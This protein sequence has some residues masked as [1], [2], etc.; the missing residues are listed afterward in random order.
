MRRTRKA[1]ND[2]GIR[3]IIATPIR[4]TVAGLAVITVIIALSDI[5]AGAVPDTTIGD[6]A[7]DHSLMA[8]GV[9]EAKRRAIITGNMTPD[10]NTTGSIGW[11]KA[12]IA[13]RDCIATDTAATRIART[14]WD[15]SRGITGATTVRSIAARRSQGNNVRATRIEK[16][17]G[18]RS[19]SASTRTTMAS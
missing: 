5:S 16:R 9:T 1:G 19:S 15:A 8:N 11:L 3:G 17:A 10:A 13:T 12:D 14:N 18:P 4:I 7:T 2:T 6:G